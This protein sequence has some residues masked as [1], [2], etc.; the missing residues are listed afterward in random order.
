MVNS[1]DLLA[2]G[3]VFDIEVR[4]GEVQNF[5]TGTIK[6]IWVDSSAEPSSYGPSP[7]SMTF[8]TPIGSSTT[9]PTTAASNVI[10][11]QATDQQKSSLA[12]SAAL[13]TA[14]SDQAGI[15][16]SKGTI[17]G[18]AAGSVCF[19]MLLSACFWYLSKIKWHNGQ[20]KHTPY[21]TE[22]MKSSDMRNSS[23]TRRDISGS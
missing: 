18:I 15:R 14:H 20:G 19:G 13:R 11:T 22:R 17:A 2:H 23:K 8:V 6:L 10:S 3:E 21:N 7:T 16:L 12:P 4:E 1:L 9:L 5:A